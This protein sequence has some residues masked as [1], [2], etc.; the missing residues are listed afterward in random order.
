MKYICIHIYL[1]IY[2]HNYE[3]VVQEGL[4]PT[5]VFLT[6]HLARYKQKHELPYLFKPHLM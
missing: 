1:F 6:Q 3:V 4:E 5:M 2:L